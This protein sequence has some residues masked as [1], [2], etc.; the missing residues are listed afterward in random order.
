MLSAENIVV[1]Y[2][3]STN[4]KQLDCV[5]VTIVPG[6]IT[7]IVGPNGSGKST[8]LRTLSRV[9][10]PKHGVVLMDGRDLY[11]AVSAPESAR[12]ISVVPQDTHVAFDFSARDVV[13]MGRMPLHTGWARFALETADDRSA[14]DA[15]LATAVLIARAL[16]QESNVILLDEPTSCLDLLHQAH[17]FYHLR[18][19][20]SSEN[21][22]VVVVLHDLGHAASIANRLI[23]LSRGKVAADGPVADV[24]TRELV[25]DVYQCDVILSREPISGSITVIVNP[26]PRFRSDRSVYVIG[27]GGGS[28]D[29]FRI[30][31]EVGCH[32]AA[33]YLNSGD[34]DQVSAKACGFPWRELPP[35]AVTPELSDD[36][37][38]KISDDFDIVVFAPAAVSEMN[39][40][41]LSAGLKLARSGMPIFCLKSSAGVATSR[42]PG[43][44]AK[45]QRLWQD[46]MSRL[47][48][49]PLADA[50][51]LIKLFSEDDYAGTA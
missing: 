27:G 25:R 4:D 15:A 49:P 8:L 10:R 18:H 48:A 37:V 12:A 9:L 21:K 35:F 36:D 50:K 20:A 6:T 7:A 11:Q 33:G 28:V 22:S 47:S 45:I 51:D 38:K 13:G 30:L 41:S 29:V 3:A 5:S 17:L 24:L 34:L 14:V 26:E 40:A 39:I 42:D 44:S 19:L 1:S 46:L 32:V 16:V 43:V 23:V 31:A 2:D